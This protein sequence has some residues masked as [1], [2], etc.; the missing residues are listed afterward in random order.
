M[1]ARHKNDPDYFW[2]RASVRGPDDC[3][4]WLGA[5]DAWGYGKIYADGRLWGAH[6]R[7]YFLKNGDIPKGAFILHRCDNP[8]CVNPEHLFA[9]SHAENMR[10]MV[11]KGRQWRRATHCR[12]GHAFTPENTGQGRSR[13]GGTYRVCRRCDADAQARYKVRKAGR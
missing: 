7:S 1:A 12:N 6:R 9:G 13:H 8:A 3:W 10:D 2:S 11:N 4:P 5:T